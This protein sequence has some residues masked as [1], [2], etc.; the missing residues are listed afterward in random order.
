VIKPDSVIRAHVKTH[1]LEFV[2][3][4]TFMHDGKVCV[5]DTSYF[6]GGVKPVTEIA[7]RP[8]LFFVHPKSGLLHAI[9]QISKRGRKVRKP[10]PPVTFRWI[11]K[12]LALKQIRGLWFE[13]HFEVVPVNVRF[14]AYDQALQRVVSRGELQ[15]CEGDFLLC[16]RKRQLCR[17]ELR[18]LGLR[19]AQLGTQFS[20]RCESVLKTALR[21][22]TSFARSE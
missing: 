12:N 6:G 17:R 18:Q 4:N 2:E 9:P 22:L 11:G 20:K 8:S 3:R 15:R 13:C 21:W 1:L 19:N 14:Q 16:I 7:W 5:L 10:Q